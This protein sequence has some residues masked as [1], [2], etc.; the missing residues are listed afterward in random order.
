MNPY[1][2]IDKFICSRCILPETF[3]GIN[4]DDNRVCNYCRQEAAAQT[5]RSVVSA[6][7]RRRLDDLIEAR[8]G[9]ESTYDAIMAYSGGKDSSYTLKLLKER[10]DLRILA[11][12]LDNNFISPTAHSNIKTIVDRLG[13]DHLTFRPSWPILKDLF[14]STAVHDS[15]SPATL[16]RASAICTAC[17]GLV[18]SLVLR[19]ALIYRIPLV[20]FG[21]SPGQAPIQAAIV[22][23][24]PSLIK[25]NQK[26]YKTGFPAHLQSQLSSYLIPESFY[27]IYKDSFPHNIHPLAF[28]PYDENAILAEIEAMGWKP[29]ANTDSNSTNCLLNAFAN[30]C[31][32]ER[33]KFHPYV[34]EIANMVR[35]GVMSRKD[36][37]DKI[38][39]PQDPGMVAY[40]REILGLEPFRA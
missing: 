35:Q 13:I 32:L 38:Y 10:Y 4:Y 27:E 21:W 5:D 14:R 24:N 23:T 3:P 15:F 33:H 25:Q 36:G 8:R 16:L 7:Y 6:E 18:K 40:A 2:S 34:M 28:F 12:T 9:G 26:A 20:A 17:I 29:P 19:T 1:E 37:I 22:K 11:I 30:Y 31:H 39:S